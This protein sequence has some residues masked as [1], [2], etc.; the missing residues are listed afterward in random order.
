M[1]ESR[2]PKPDRPGEAER[3][4]NAK[5]S[6]ERIAERIGRFVKRPAGSQPLA[7]AR[8]ESGEH[9]ARGAKPIKVLAR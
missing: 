1:S 6:Y 7:P 8:W 5:A 3:L 9:I 2:A 4:A